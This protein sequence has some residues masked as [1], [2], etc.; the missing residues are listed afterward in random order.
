MPAH[1]DALDERTPRRRLRGS[2]RRARIEAAAL[3][4]F[5]HRGYDATSLGEV[6]AAAGVARTVMYDHFPDK[7]ALFLSVMASQQ[8]LML[9][10]I[11]GGITSEG[12]PRS[13]VRAT[14]AAYLAFTQDH[15]ATRRL[16]LAPIPSGDS[17]L[18]EVVQGYL[19]ARSDAIGMLLSADLTRAGVDLAS[20]SFPVIVALV[21]GA[22]DGVAQWWAINPDVPLDDAVE[23]AT[24]LLWNGL[25]RA[26]EA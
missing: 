5:A 19:S 22:V 24:R 7:R 25:P 9:R 15:P 11:A 3:V 14:V 26:G 20:V 2:E 10:E 1:P 13:R 18:D 8:E 6:A 12:D 4:A 21:S 23:A 16:L 17:E